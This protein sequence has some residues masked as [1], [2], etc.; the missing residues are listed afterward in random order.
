MQHPYTQHSTM[1]NAQY[2][3]PKND[4]T[5]RNTRTSR[6][7]FSLKSNIFFSLQV[8][9]GNTRHTTQRSGA[10]KLTQRT[11]AQNTI[12]Q[13]KRL[14][15]TLNKCEKENTRLSWINSIFS[16]RD[17]QTYRQTYSSLF[18][19]SSLLL[20]FRLHLNEM[21]STMVKGKSYM[22]I[23]ACD[24][25]HCTRRTDGRVYVCL[26]WYGYCWA[27]S[28]DLQKAIDRIRRR[29]EPER[30]HT[31]VLKMMEEHHGHTKNEKNSLE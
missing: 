8:I 1:N 25:P 5:K 24:C 29:K 22:Y 27:L 7:S 13:R 2:N 30:T 10:H 19:V 26:C 6:Y 4:E 17:T 11:I 31:P 16:F 20:S 14:K 12:V 18:L 3:F 9:N 28:S 15:R 23:H 21:H